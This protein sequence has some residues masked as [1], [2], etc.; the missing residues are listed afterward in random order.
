MAR[1]E[2]VKQKREP[3]KRWPPQGYNTCA[4]IRIVGPIKRGSSTGGLVY[5]GYDSNGEEVNGKV[6][7]VLSVP[8][9]LARLSANKLIESGLAAPYGSG[10]KYKEARTLA[11]KP[12]PIDKIKVIGGRTSGT[13]HLCVDPEGNR[14]RA[15]IGDVFSVLDDQITEE[16]AA[17]LINKRI[18]ERCK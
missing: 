10:E 16:V 9:D 15:S 1:T 4:K 5:L 13:F 18:A 3:R 14:I 6:G 12:E 11:S 7:S 17:A 2:E 8:K